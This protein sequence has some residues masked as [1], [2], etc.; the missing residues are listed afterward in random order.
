VAPINE[1]HIVSSRAISIYDL[2]G[3][4][5]WF[6]G[7]ALVAV[8]AACG[9]GQSESAGSELS[10][11]RVKKADPTLAAQPISVVNTTA[12]G[13][14]S[15]RTIGA[16]ADGSYTVAWISGSTLYMQRYDSA[17]NKSSTETVV[18]VVLDPRDSASQVLASSSMEV[19]TDGS[20]VVAYTTRRSTVDPSSP[21]VTEDG[22]YMQRF[23]A[24]G[25]QVLPET[26]LVSRVENDPRRPTIFGA[27]KVLA[28]ADGGFVIGWGSFSTS[29][30]VG[31]RNSFFTRRFDSQSQAVGGA[32]DIGI[33]GT[34]LAQ[35]QLTADANGGYT[36]YWFGTGPDLLPNG[37]T[38]THYD[39]N[40][41]AA[42]ILTSWSGSALLLPLEDGRY[43]LYTSDAGAYRQMLDRAGNPVGGRTPVLSMPVSAQELV[44]GSYVV[45]W[46][47]SGGT[48]AQRFDSSGAPMGDVLTIQTSGAQASVAALA[49]DGFAAAWSADSAAGDLDV[50]TQRFIEVADNQRKACLKSAKGLKGQ[51]RKAFMGTCLR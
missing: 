16:L 39:A 15:L 19:L 28:M 29:A 45:F 9:G 18:P 47:T 6:A 25:V 17:G 21:V 51:E 50:Y 24:N 42:Q 2:F 49:E 8:L 10:A 13:D 35:Y 22:V 41:M 14:Q 23:D 34:P 20:V 30:T 44:D 36:A 48:T 46:S 7:M 38:V 12:A 31:S 27:T 4:L 33:G 32:V 37:V 1:K 3:T 5:R 40:Q 26:Q 11:A 43:V